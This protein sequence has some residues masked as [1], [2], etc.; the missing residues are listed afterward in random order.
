[1][2]HEEEDFI[3]SLTWS[4][5][6]M[7]RCLKYSGPTADAAASAPLGDMNAEEGVRSRS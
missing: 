5:C 6:D 3:L 7:F 1:M 2:R 4:E